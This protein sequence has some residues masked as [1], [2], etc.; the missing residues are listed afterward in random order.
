MD[1]VNNLPTN[2]VKL[3]KLF[4]FVKREWTGFTSMISY[5]CWFVIYRPRGDKILLR[6]IPRIIVRQ[7]CMFSWRRVYQ[8]NIKDHG[9]THVRW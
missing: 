5:N 6:T 4:F 2:L 8:S 3:L 9:N 1:K 7:T